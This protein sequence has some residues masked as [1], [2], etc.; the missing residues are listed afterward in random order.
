MR[1]MTYMPL[2][3]FALEVPVDLRLLVEVPDH[4]DAE[5]LGETVSNALI[6][7]GPTASTLGTFWNQC[8]ASISHASSKSFT[9]GTSSRGFRAKLPADGCPQANV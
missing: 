7:S 5:A 3:G 4:F 9:D 1:R 2:C 6:L 8:E